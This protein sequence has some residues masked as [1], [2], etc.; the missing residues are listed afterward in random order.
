MDLRAHLCP[1]QIEVICVAVQTLVS[2]AWYAI[3]ITGCVSAWIHN[4]LAF[5]QPFKFIFMWPFSF[6]I[7]TNRS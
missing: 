1:L 6:E 3:P 5:H 7:T 2:T 4:V